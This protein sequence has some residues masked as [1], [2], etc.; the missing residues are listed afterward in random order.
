M[1]NVIGRAIVDSTLSESIAEDSSFCNECLI[2]IEYK[3]AIEN[4]SI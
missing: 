3:Y 2:F 4:V 1:F